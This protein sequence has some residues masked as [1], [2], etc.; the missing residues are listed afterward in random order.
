MRDAWTQ[1]LSEAA[2]LVAAVFGWAGAPA[3][4]AAD[5]ATSAHK[6]SV[7]IMGAPRGLRLN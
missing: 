7:L 4:P 3:Q 6:K 2:L 5:A 1:S